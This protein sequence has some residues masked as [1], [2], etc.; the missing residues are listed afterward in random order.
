MEE[1]DNVA[2][3]QDVVQILSVL[4]EKRNLPWRRRIDNVDFLAAGIVRQFVVDRY[5]KGLAAAIDRIEDNF[6]A[7]ND[8]VSSGSQF[9][10]RQNVEPGTVVS[11]WVQRDAHCVLLQQ[12]GKSFVDGQIFVGFQMQE[13]LVEEALFIYLRDWY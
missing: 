6:I 7:Q 4:H 12:G 3:F 8:R 5:V 2:A 10:E 1:T 11:R 13:L 9:V